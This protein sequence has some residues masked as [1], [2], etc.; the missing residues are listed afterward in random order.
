[1]RK[2]FISYSHQD[3]MFAQRLAEDLRKEV[4]VVWID[5]QEIQVGDSLVDRIA[6]GLRRHDYFVPV[7]SPGYV[8][9]QWC[10]RELSVATRLDIENSVAVLP[11]LLRRCPIPELISD[12]LYADFTGDYEEGYTTLLAAISNA[13]RTRQTLQKKEGLVI[14]DF[15]YHHLSSRSLVTERGKDRTISHDI[16]YTRSVINKPA[17]DDFSI[18]FD[19]T[20]CGDAELRIT[21]IDINVESWRPL[22]PTMYGLMKVGISHARIFFGHFGKDTG[23]YPLTFAV[24]D[25]YV[26]LAKRE[27]E[28]IHLTINTEDEGIYDLKVTVFY[29]MMGASKSVE[30]PVMKDLW[31]VDSDKYWGRGQ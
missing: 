3:S 2:L 19:I 16:T 12:K 18:E 15:Q 20:N 28:V 11:V 21:G 17:P 26:K 22:K 27:M 13:K 23:A 9:S 24:P 30:T 25:G 14:G 5:T 31:F 6:Q 1:M 10:A 8:E 29:S 4:V 7:L